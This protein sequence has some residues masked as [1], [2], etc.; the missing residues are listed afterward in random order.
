MSNK[1]VPLTEAYSAY[2]QP[3]EPQILEEIPK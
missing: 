3:L 1:T 2:T